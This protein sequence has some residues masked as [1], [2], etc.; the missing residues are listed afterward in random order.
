[1]YRKERI[2]RL[3]AAKVNIEEVANITGSTIIYVKSLVSDPSFREMV[4]LVATEL[5]EVESATDLK[6]VEE[7]S[8]ATRLLE[9]EHKALKTVV[10]NLGMM[11][12]RSMIAAF[13][14]IST[15]RDNLDKGKATGRALAAMEGGTIPFVN[16]VL[17]TIVIPELAMNS[18]KEIIGLGNR[19]TVP[20]QRDA[21]LE[22]LESG[23][24]SHE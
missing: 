18:Q 2:A 14:A 13:Q 8:L 17:P 11:E 6:A 16:L 24:N 10:D 23:G 9:A 15:R 5:D 20:M 1:M 3:L 22:L 21:V 12:H 19:T 4:E 7:E